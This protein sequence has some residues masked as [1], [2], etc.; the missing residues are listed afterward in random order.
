MIHIHQKEE[1]MFTL[2]LPKRPRID[3]TQF[4]VT[5]ESKDKKELIRLAKQ[6]G[7]TLHRLVKGILLGYIEHKNN[8]KQNI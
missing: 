1:I 8:S 6:E 2:I 3:N 5:I 7:F 4:T